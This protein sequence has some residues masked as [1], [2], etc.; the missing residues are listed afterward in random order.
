MVSK[1]LSVKGWP[2]GMP[3]DSEETVAFA[4]LSGVK[5]KIQK[6]PLSQAAEAYKA[7]IS[8]QVR[9]RAVIVP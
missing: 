1:R 3:K 5:A 8:G 7:M 2:S 6:F 9:F 4:K